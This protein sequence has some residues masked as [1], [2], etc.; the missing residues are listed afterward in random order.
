M[1]GI[2]D[3]LKPLL[4]AKPPPAKEIELA[5]GGTRVVGWLRNVGKK[6]LVHYTYSR[7]QG[8][9]RIATWV[10]HLALLASGHGSESWLVTR[11][12]DASSCERY[13]AVDH[14]D[15]ELATLVDLYWRGL[16][17]PLLFF[18]DPSFD[19]AAHAPT[20][21]HEN[22]VHKARRSFTSQFGLASC[23][24]V[25]RVLGDRD[26]FEDDFEPFGSARDKRRFPPFG[27]LA[28]TIVK[29]LLSHEEHVE[30]KGR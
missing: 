7:L 25:R 27:A 1:T 16:E 18:A 10:R 23:P 14:A 12:K 8:K 28:T 29:P 19:Y 4:G 17:A 15:E 6:G 30:E 20:I 24:Y 9:N 11:T 21:G 2:A 3:A 26:P 13:R 22:A 5:I